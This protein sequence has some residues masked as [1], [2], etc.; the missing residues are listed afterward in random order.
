M[1]SH[2]WGKRSRKS[3]EAGQAIVF[4][5]LAMSLALL[6]AIAFAVDLGN[7][8]FN[9]QSAQGAADAACTAAAMDMLG[10]ATGG[11][12]MGGF[13]PGTTFSCS[14]SPTAAPCIYAKKNMGYAPSSLTAGTSGY[15]VAFSFPTSV[16]GLPTCGTG[17]GAPAI[18]NDPSALANNFIQANVDDRVQ[19]YFAGVLSGSTATDVGAQST[20]GVVAAN[21]PIPLLVLDPRNETSVTNNGNFNITI[22]GGPQKSVQ[23]DSSSTTAVSISG[24][25]GRIDLTQGGPND[26][27]SDFGVTG[28][29][30]VV[31]VFYTANSGK[32]I[33]PSARISDPFALI[34][35]PGTQ[36]AA[37]AV[38]YKQTGASA[39]AWGCPDTTNGCDHYHPGY[40]AGGI[41][42]KA[43]QPSGATGLAV[44]D[45]GI[46]YLGG[47]GLSADSN[48]CL[49]PSTATGDGSGG[50]IFYFSGTATASVTANSGTL[51]QG[52]GSAR[53]FDC[54][55]LNTST[56]P[57]TIANAAWAVSLNQ[58]R[59]ITSGTGTTTLPANVITLGGL[60]GNVLLGPCR[61]PTAGGYNYGDP[62]GV[63]DPLGEQ[64]G[65]LL[66][67]NR[68]QSS[69]L[70]LWSGGGAFGLAGNLYFHN[71]LAGS[72]GGGNCDTTNGFTDLLELGGGSSSDTFVV[73]DIVTDKLYLH[74]NPQIE[75]DLN[76][77]ALY[78]VF[79][80]SL[81]Q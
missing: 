67:Q 78:Y 43:N 47:V 34:P 77:N 10:T 56:T 48:S 59:C 17:I 13:T 53:T 76:P 58:V 24:G 49:R 81:L 12:A 19:L 46:Y 6:G 35:A 31:S 20:C 5:V 72:S 62:L 69:V 80:A 55:D 71:C 50:T 57:P 18:C 40:Y 74:G 21:S 33:D 63:N 11:G 52:P 8:W 28:S 64:R 4:V 73:G 70:P 60:V 66:F 54:Q 30:P 32:W 16:A 41:Q 3:D 79:K 25:V 39:A 29:E 7:L 65:M 22:V 2:R 38:N 14:S 61:A 36:P 1:T 37:P 26:N 68:S 15:D 27:G 42:V 23:V 51:K 75:M 44:F 45:P 9:R